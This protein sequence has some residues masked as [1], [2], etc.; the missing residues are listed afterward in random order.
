MGTWLHYQ[1]ESIMRSS[2]IIPVILLLAVVGS[3][4]AWH[5]SPEK[6]ADRLIRQALGEMSA[7]ADAQDQALLLSHIDQYFSPDTEVKLNV[8]FALF[9]IGSGGG[10]GWNYTHDRAQFKDFIAEMIGKVDTYGMRLSLTELTLDESD[11]TQFTATINPGGFATGGA[12]ASGRKIGT[13]YVIGGNCTA[14]GTISNNVQI[15]LME[16]PIKLN[17]QVDLKGV[18]LGDTIKELQGRKP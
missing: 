13:R 2:T 5:F 11:Q 16:C 4:A 3:M 10:R 12:L 17:Q 6:K 1:F 8:K 18:K 14:S 7:A 9:A 15:Q